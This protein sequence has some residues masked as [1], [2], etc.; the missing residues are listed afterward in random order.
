M[1]LHKLLCCDNDFAYQINTEDL[2]LITRF[3]NSVVVD[4]HV[5]TSKSVDHSVEGRFKI[6][7]T[8]PY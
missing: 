2:L 6:I 1:T 5:K 7:E 4:Q 8:I 3:R